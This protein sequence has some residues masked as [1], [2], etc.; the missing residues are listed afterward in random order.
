MMRGATLWIAGVTAML[1]LPA[2][3]VI[4]HPEDDAV[5]F[6]APHPDVVGLWNNNA[7]AVAIGPSYAITTRHQDGNLNSTITF[8]GIT[9][10]V[11]EIHNI[12]NVDL[13]V[14]RLE[15]NGAPANLTQWVNVF[16]GNDNNFSQQFVMGGYGRDRGNAL[17]TINGTYGYEWGTGPTATPQWGQNRIEGAQNSLFAGPYASNVLLADFDRTDLPAEA[18]LTEYDSGGGWF[19]RNN[20]EWQVRALSLGVIHSDPNP[21][22]NPYDDRALFA[23]HLDANEDAPDIMVGVRLANYYNEIHQVIPEPS[24]ALLLVLGAISLMIRRQ[25]S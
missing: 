15:L 10:D 17:T 25:S 3:G 7:S 1:T 6:D 18:I 12:G 16:D 23:S 4:R 20:D 11:V 13:R 14:V 5:T 19:V 21:N 2:A 24:S 22:P 8:G 9:Y